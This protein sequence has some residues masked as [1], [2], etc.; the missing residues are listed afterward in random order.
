MMPLIKCSDCGKLVSDLAPACIGCGKPLNT[1][2]YPQPLPVQT[3]PEAQQSKAQRSAALSDLKEIKRH[4][5]K[6]IFFIMLWVLLLFWG[7]YDLWDTYSFLSVSEPAEAIVLS[8]S[9]YRYGKGRTAY[10]IS[11]MFSVNGYDYRGT[12]SVSTLPSSED[13]IILYNRNNPN[14]NMAHK[15][16]TTT[17]WVLIGLGILS[18]VIFSGVL[19]R[20]RD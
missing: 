5:K 6:N 2:L 15:P 11:Y 7:L 17:G 4:A 19:K 18:V 8:S 16:D 20:F 14:E 1:I 3:K 10:T 9:S 13:I 12:D